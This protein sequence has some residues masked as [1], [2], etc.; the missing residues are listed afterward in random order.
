MGVRQRM[1]SGDEEPTTTTKL[2][3]PEKGVSVPNS[4][5]TSTTV[6]LAVTIVGMV[7][8]YLGKSALM[9]GTG[10][11]FSMVCFAHFLDKFR[12][13]YHIHQKIVV[14]DLQ[15]TGTELNQGCSSTNV[16]MQEFNLM[17]DHIFPIFDFGVMKVLQSDLPAVSKQEHLHAKMHREAAKAENGRVE[18]PLKRWTWLYLLTDFLILRCGKMMTITLCGATE[19]STYLWGYAPFCYMDKYMDNVLLFHFMEESE[20]SMLTVQGFKKQGSVILNFVLYPLFAIFTF[21]LFFLPPYVRMLAEPSL[22]LNPKT[23][24]D[25]VKFHLFMTVIYIGAN[26][27]VIA[28][29][30]FPLPMSIGLHEFVLDRFM[31]EL[32]LRGVK[33]EDTYSETYICHQ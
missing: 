31:D 29:W 16:H 11:A 9:S 4:I 8:W 21:V 7:P 13:R 6:L 12:G 3:D 20:H 26:L 2:V 28:H 32:K 1:A 5:G 14:R 23:Y 33:F 25:L 30:V 27:G 19:A 10:M 18:D 24:I 17:L 22:L 15:S